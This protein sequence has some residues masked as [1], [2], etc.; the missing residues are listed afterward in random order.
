MILGGYMNILISLILASVLWGI[1]VVSIILRS[2]NNNE[3]VEHRNYKYKYGLDVN[4]DVEETRHALKK[5]S[6]RPRKKKSRK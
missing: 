1:L 3:Y 4:K 2:L 5:K 6:A